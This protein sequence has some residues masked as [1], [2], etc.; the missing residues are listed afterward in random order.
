MRR[1]PRVLDVLDGPIDDRKMTL[2]G[3]QH[4][5]T[6][7]SA[8]TSFKRVIDGAV[9]G[10]SVTVRRD[11]DS[12]AVVDATRYRRFLA[13]TVAADVRV[14]EEDGVFAMIMA[15]PAIAVEDEDYEA[16]VADMVLALREYAEDWQDHLLSAP[17]H[18]EN[19]GL[20][21]LVELSDDAQLTA[22]LLGTDE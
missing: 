20:V 7:S 13:R 19:W 2:L 11:G 8:R 16:L 15:D 9:R 18:A 4:Y 10:S 3:A 12:V 5:D 21:Q 1:V 6:T 22:W 14:L 17:N